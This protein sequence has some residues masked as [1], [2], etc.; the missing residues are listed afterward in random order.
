MDFI[1][2]TGC[3]CADALRLKAGDFQNGHVF[4]STA[5]K[6]GGLRQYRIAAPSNAEELIEGLNDEAPVFPQWPHYPR[7]I[8]KACKHIKNKDP[9]FRPF[10][11]HSLRHM[12]ASAM[13]K[14]KATLWDI[15]RQLGHNPVSTT[16][17]YM[18]QM[19]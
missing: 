12:K 19:A 10:S 18:Q 5:K 11:I 14:A 6:K 17:R 15:S 7:F 8:E 9:T 4:I 16:E 13:N 2:H 3:R 1:K